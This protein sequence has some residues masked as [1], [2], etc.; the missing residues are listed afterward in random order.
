[1]VTHKAGVMIYRMKKELYGQT[2]NERDTDLVRC[3]V[4][5][6]TARVLVIH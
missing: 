4:P 5:H 6:D 1:M 3:F 2:E